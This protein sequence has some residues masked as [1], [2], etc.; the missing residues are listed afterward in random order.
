MRKRGSN[1]WSLSTSV[2]VL[3]GAKSMMLRTWQVH[4]GTAAPGAMQRMLPAVCSLG[5]QDVGEEH[6]SQLPEVEELVSATAQ[7][8][9]E[10]RAILLQGSLLKKLSVL[11][12]N[13]K[14]GVIRFYPLLLGINFLKITLS[15]I[16]L[17]LALLIISMCFMEAFRSFWV[18]R[19]VTSTWGR[20][21][22]KKDWLVFIQIF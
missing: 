7:G 19:D 22:E 13:G 3:G 12:F 8:H 14:S 4:G 17:C 6:L 1:E 20:P 2:F 10:V 11:N 18:M 5:G 9:M 21:K 16:P 15:F